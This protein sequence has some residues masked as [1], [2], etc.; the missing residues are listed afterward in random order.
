M[1]WEE[2]KYYQDSKGHL[3]LS[4]V[5]TDARWRTSRPSKPPELNYQDNA[6]VDR[7]GFILSRGVTHASEREWKALPQLL[8]HLPLPPVSLAA[9]TALGGTGH[10][11]LYPHPSQA[12][13]EHGG[14]RG[15]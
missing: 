1:G 9:D 5:G 2:T 6:I 11:G 3:P 4:P 7:G 14:Q 13:I 15:L 8:E 12:G 10:H